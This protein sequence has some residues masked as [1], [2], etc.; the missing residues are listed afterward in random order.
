MSSVQPSLS[1]QQAINSPCFPPEVFLEVF[2]FADRTTLA[3]LCLV[4]T[5]F[6]RL[7]APLLY[8]TV[9]FDEVSFIIEDPDFLSVRSSRLSLNDFPPPFSLV[10]T[11]H[12]TLLDENKSIP[13]PQ[14]DMPKLQHLHIHLPYDQNF[15][16]L[17]LFPSMIDYSELLPDLNPVSITFHLT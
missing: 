15:D 16:Y 13:F 1:V 14:T 9:H 17:A 2:S 8:D 5:A 4:D 11:L 7:T 10:K 6:F 3:S 12:F